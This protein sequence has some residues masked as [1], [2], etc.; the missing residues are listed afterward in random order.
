MNEDPTARVAGQDDNSR[1]AYKRQGEHTRVTQRE[2]ILESLKYAKGGMTAKELELALNLSHNTVSSRLINLM[3]Q[4]LVHRPGQKRRGAWINYLGSGPVKR[5]RTKD[6][7]SRQRLEALEH[8]CE[9]VRV[10][11]RKGRL[12][13]VGLEAMD[14][15][16]VSLG[17]PR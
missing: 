14:Q 15:V 10:T 16:L 9:T 7:V 11:I 17:Y 5:R 1:D 13:G 6:G 4:G 2:R 8:F 3:D 12:E